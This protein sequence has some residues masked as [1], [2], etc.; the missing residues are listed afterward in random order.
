MLRIHNSMTKKKEIFKPLNPPLVNLYVCGVTVYDRCHLGHA[1]SMICFDV[2][3]R[4]LRASGYKVKFV[5]NITDIDDKIIRRSK[6]LNISFQDLALQNITDM[7]TDIKKLR[8]L[9]PDSEPKAT[10]YVQ[11]M[12]NLIMQLFAKDLAY[13]TESGDV[14]FEVERFKPYGKLSHQNLDGL[15]EGARVEIGEHKRSALDFVL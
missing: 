8:L 9:A 10:E 11:E 7:H 3:V 5:R 4:F 14:C 2:I 12:I 1:R 6:E 13:V 15:L